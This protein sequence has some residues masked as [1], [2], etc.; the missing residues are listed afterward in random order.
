MLLLFFSVLWNIE[1]KLEHV[2]PHKSV[3]FLPSK[4]YGNSF[5]PNLTK[6]DHEEG[7]E[8][9]FEIRSGFFGFFKLKYS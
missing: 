6:S 5:L 1:L 3:W 8:A 2:F 4:V 7:R 9:H